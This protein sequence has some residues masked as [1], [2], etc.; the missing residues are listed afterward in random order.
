MYI[1]ILPGCLKYVFFVVMYHP[2][3]PDDNPK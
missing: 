2:S 3:N 1:N